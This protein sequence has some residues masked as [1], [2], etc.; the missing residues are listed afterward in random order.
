MLGETVHLVWNCNRQLYHAWRTSE[1]WSQATTV[2]IGEQLAL[3]ATPDGQLHCLFVNQFARNYEIYHVL[4]GRTD[5]CTLHGR[6]PRRATRLSTTV[7]VSR[8]SGAL[9]RYLAA[10]APLRPSRPRPTARSSSRGRT[11]AATPATTTSSAAPIA[12][13][14]GSLPSPCRTARASTPYC[15][16]RLRPNREK[17]T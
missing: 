13:I 10:A 2:A 16:S 17:S 7:R 5:P 8:S 12:T 15:P 4:L 3:A 1:G 9:A 14:R 6:T 11:A